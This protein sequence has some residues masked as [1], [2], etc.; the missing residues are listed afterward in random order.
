MQEV[1]STLREVELAA[2]E[3]LTAPWTNTGRRSK[4]RTQSIFT[5]EY[6]TR[7]ITCHSWPMGKNWALRNA[8][9]IAASDPPT[10]IALC[11]EVKQLRARVKFLDDTLQA[12]KME[13]PK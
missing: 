5:P 6:A 1:D 4:H 3:A 9:H 12:K 7:I 11:E 8:N 13:S 10:V 2:R